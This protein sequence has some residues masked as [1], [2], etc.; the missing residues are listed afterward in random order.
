MALAAKY[1]K[2]SRAGT[3]DTDPGLSYQAQALG[4]SAPI[5]RDVARV[6]RSQSEDTDWRPSTSVREDE[7]GR[8]GGS[9]GLT[10]ALHPERAAR[11][12]TVSH[13]EANP[14]LANAEAIV[15]G[16]REA[17]AS[18]RRRIAGEVIAA[19]VRP[20]A[21][22][23]SEFD[24]GKGMVPNADWS[25]MSRFIET[26]VIR[27][28]AAKGLEVNVY[29]SAAPRQANRMVNGRYESQFGRQAETRMGKSGKQEFRSHT[30]DPA[31]LGDAPGRIFGGNAVVDYRG[32]SGVR[33][34]V[35]RPKE[36]GEDITAR[37]DMGGL[38]EIF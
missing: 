19:G 34:K 32:L 20:T 25:R 4:R 1:S 10:P 31:V 13:A 12:T 6:Y 2:T 3:H 27:T 8:L 26:P 7:G 14:A 35:V 18:G 29:K 28:G 36:V 9:A 15:R 38:G 5:Q 33:T 37:D 24:G 16:L 30:Q 21:L 22:A 11:S 23:E 17:T